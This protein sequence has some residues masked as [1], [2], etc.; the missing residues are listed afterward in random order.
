MRKLFIYGTVLN[1]AEWVEG[2]IASLERLKPSWIIITDAGSTDGTKEILKGLSWKYGNIL[3]EN[4]KGASRGR[5]RQIALE[6]V[7]NV[8]DDNDS[9]MYV[10]FDN[11]YS[12]YSANYIF[13]KNKVVNDNEVYCFGLMTIRTSKLA[14]WKDLNYGED[15][16]YFAHLKSRGV[17]IMD[18]IKEDDAR[19]WTESQRQGIGMKER[20]RYYNRG[21]IAMFHNLIDSHK[22]IAYKNWTGDARHTTSKIANII[23]HLLAH[24]YA[25]DSELNNRDFVWQRQS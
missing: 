1:N 5:G 18:F 4:S 6:S 25:Y 24:P 22:G 7:Y 14:E 10:D 19:K 13:Q 21:R 17:K 20:E 16:E 8:A 3:I 11:V 15:Y 23:A 9:V 2:S 12:I